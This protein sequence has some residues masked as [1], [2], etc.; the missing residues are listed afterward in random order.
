MKKGLSFLLCLAM[1]CTLAILPASA[2]EKVTLSVW[3]PGSG[4]ATYDQAWNTVLSAYTQQHPEVS[5]DISFV[6]WGEFFTK[7]NAAFAGG[8]GPDLFGIGY[9]QLGT[10]QANDRLLNLGDYLPGDWDGWTDIPENILSVGQKDGGTYA[11]LMPDVRTLLYRKDIAEKNG[12]T[13]D[14]L[15]FSS[16]G[17]L[18]ALAEKMTVRDENGNII[19]AGLE[20]RTSA[21]ISNEQ[22]FFIFSHWMGGGN[23]WNDDLTANFNQEENAAALAKMKE[24][25]DSGCAVLSEPGDGV[26]QIVNGTAAMSLNIES[27]LASSRQAFDTG[28]IA[29]NM[30]TLTLGVFYGANAK[31]A[32]PEVCADVLSYIF[33]PESQKVFAE[34]M[35]MTPSR[36]S[37]AEWFIQQDADG[38]N[39]EII[40]MYEKAIPYSPFMNKEFLNLMSL[41]RP[42]IED[43]FYNG[44]DPAAALTDCAEQYNALF[45]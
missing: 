25:L 20:L 45:E 12:V 26:Y 30:E 27:A 33:G 42:A 6:P 32:H 23:L 21:A 17:E 19:V 41:L 39:A 9:G 18:L 37:L 15:R 34:V 36:Q 11:F 24:F 10:L 28:A 4:D 22:N 44:A 16:V 40:K 7:L 35:G 43:V 38:D 2:T 5:Y 1:L 3:I 31:T 8:V 29:F 14:E 13:D